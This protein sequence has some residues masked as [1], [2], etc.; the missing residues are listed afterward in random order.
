MTEVIVGSWRMIVTAWRLD[1]RKTVF[2]VVLMLA[3]AVAGP[4]LAVV[5]GWMANAVVA[6]DWRAAAAAGVVAAFLAIMALTFSHFAHLAHFE[7]SE[8]TEVD[9]DQQLLTLSNGSAGIAHHEQ[10]EHA[11]ALTVLQRDANK[12]RFC[13]DALL[14]CVSLGLAGVLTGVLLVLVNPALLLLPLAALPPLLSGRW[15]E[16]IL[17]RAKTATAEPTRVAQNLFRS[18]TSA[19]AAGELRVFRLQREFQR[20][21]AQH[22]DVAT[23][24]LVRAQV[25]AAWVR[26]LGQVAF[27]LAY[28]G[29]VLL[30]VREAIAGRRSIGD[31]VLLIAL[32]AQ[33]NQQVVT[34]VG[35]LQD[36][37]QLA[38]AYRRLDQVRATVADPRAIQAQRPAPSRLRDG[39]ELAGVSFTYPGTKTP[40]LRDVSL[41]LPAGATVALVG[42]NGAGKTTLIN[43]LCGFYRPSEGQ[44]LLD[45]VAL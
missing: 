25:R 27:A 24:K 11:D 40:V 1:R 29:A 34:A 16:R 44:I 33:V 43:L 45:G 12:F 6:G 10:A 41:R 36:L 21:H 31:V 7:L 28:V 26:T 13:L 15:A 9:F 35:L 5:L 32:A 2:A 14:N 4:M 8:L 17:D 39:I 3:G 37:Q 23:R 22:W 30:V 42:E 18:C 38:S 20:R 19:S